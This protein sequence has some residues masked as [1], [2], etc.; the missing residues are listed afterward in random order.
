MLTSANGNRYR[1]NMPLTK[2]IDR[3]P[4]IPAFCQKYI[5]EIIQAIH[6]GALKGNESYPYKIKKKLADESEGRISLN[7]SKYKYSEQK[8]EE[9][10]NAP[11]RKKKK[12]LKTVQYF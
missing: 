1:E 8:A 4:F 3:F 7:L 2:Y 6:K 5:N 12:K 9:I 11:R 10:E